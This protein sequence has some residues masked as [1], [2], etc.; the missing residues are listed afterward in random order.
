MKMGLHRDSSVFAHVS[1]FYAEIRRRLWFTVVEL[2]LQ[3]AVSAGM[4]PS[5]NLAHCTCHY[6]MNI[7]D[8]ELREDAS[9]GDLVSKDISVCTRTAFQIVLLQSLPL[10]TEIA[11]AAAMP[12]GPPSD[13]SIIS[14]DT[15][16]T[17]WYT[18]MP[19]YCRARTA[20]LPLDIGQSCAIPSQIL[21]LTYY[22]SLLTLHAPVMAHEESRTY[23]QQQ[24]VRAAI[25]TLSQVQRQHLDAPFSRSI[26]K[27]SGEM[28]RDRILHAAIVLCLELLRHRSCGDKQH[29]PCGPD[30][31]AKSYTR[32]H[33]QILE[34]LESADAYFIHHLKRGLCTPKQFL[35]L[36]MAVASAK[37][38][39]HRGSPLHAVKDEFKAAVSE[40][41]SYYAA[42]A[43][44]RGGVSPMAN[45][46][47]TGF[48]EEYSWSPLLTQEDISAI[49]ESTWSTSLFEELMAEFDAQQYG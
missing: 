26:A 3:A 27:L 24:A 15:K 2:D 33:K 14:L 44:Q 16:L 39:L 4:P 12:A 25:Q 32:G 7:H 34:A 11:N 46:F 10:R 6:P 13:E 42:L 5:V 9:A 23:S 49:E 47:A 8:D 37:A 43:S 41:K 29:K 35:F 1:P 45:A 19:D 21:T 30:A 17:E 36:R 28:I 22:G 18:N 40:C 31:P 20:S 48:P 38:R